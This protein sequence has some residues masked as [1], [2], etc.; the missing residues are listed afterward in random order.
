MSGHDEA[1]RAAARL[2]RRAGFGATGP[3]VDAAARQV[4]AA[5]L[6]SVFAAAPD[7]SLAAPSFPPLAR[8]PRAASSTERKAANKQLAAQRT[9]LAVWWLQRMVATRTPLAEKLTFCWHNHFATS[10]QKVRSARW[11]LMQNQRLRDLGRGDFHTL[12]LAMLTDAAMLR[13]L[14]GDK[15]TKAAPNENLARE[16]MELFALG[17]GDGYTETDVRAGAKALTGWRIRPDG[18]TYLDAARHDDAPQTFLG[19]SGVH[20]VAGYCAAVLSRP[21]SPGYVAARWWGQLVSGN[22]P[23][24]AA[25]AAVTAAYGPKRDLTAMFTTMLARPEFAAAQGTLVIDPVEWLV[26][27]LRTL[28]V[29]VTERKTATQLLRV[30]Q[31][32]GQEPFYPP[33]VGGWP[34][35]QAWLSTA[36][37]D[38]RLRAASRIAAKAD[39][40]AVEHAPSASRLDAVAYLLGVATWSDRSA[41]ALRPELGAPARLV[42]VALN[43]PEYLVH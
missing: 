29:P 20:D 15:N 34:S 28:R 9:D 42:A 36:A 4:S 25:L 27:A 22:A 2:V 38:L 24:S 26:G 19:V 8:K 6:R 12:A 41:A 40:S 14:D 13:W 21:A 32:L 1:W 43:T 3:D 33:S 5:Y 11:M 35:G 10:V 18:G 23:S 7:E 37:A 30:L 16:F 39:L 31:A 17:H